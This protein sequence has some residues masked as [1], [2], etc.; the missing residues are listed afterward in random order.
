MSTAPGRIYLL[1]DVGG[2]GWRLSL[3]RMCT[4]NYQNVEYIRADIQQEKIDKLLAACDTAKTWL[5][6]CSKVAAEN[7]IETKDVGKALAQINEAIN[8]AGRSHT[9][10]L[11]NCIIISLGAT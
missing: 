1:P 5:T 2:T 3:R 9:L 8:L 11:A 7:N 6:I 10:R 4:P